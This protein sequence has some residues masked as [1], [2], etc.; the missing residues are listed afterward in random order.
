MFQTVWIKQ[1]ELTT[2]MSALT[3]SFDMKS[4]HSQTFHEHKTRRQK[5][6]LFLVLI[7]VLYCTHRSCH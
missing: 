6:G 4:L 1:A 3:R 7:N 2:A 5:S